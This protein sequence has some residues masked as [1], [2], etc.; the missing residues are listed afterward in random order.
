SLPASH[1]PLVRSL[2]APSLY[3]FSHATPPPPFASHRFA[4]R[5]VPPQNRFALLLEM[6]FLYALSDAKPLRTFAGNAMSLRI[7]P[8]KNASHFC[9]KCFVST[10]YP[11]QNRF[12]L[13][14]EMLCLYALSHAKPLRTFAGNALA[15]AIGLAPGVLIADFFYRVRAIAFCRIGE[16]LP[17][18]T[19][20]TC[21]PGCRGRLA[22]RQ[23]DEQHQHA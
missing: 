2:R 5:L 14:L 13:L 18:Q 22:P 6:L 21:C 17:Y 20:F 9:W 23:K 3:A 8:R 16:R 19:D 4:L 1:T 15:G 7:I 12:A 10:H 11:T